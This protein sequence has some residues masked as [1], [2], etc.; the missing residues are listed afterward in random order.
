METQLKKQLIKE[1]EVLKKIEEF[2]FFEKE[3]QIRQT[4]KFF[5]VFILGIMIFH[6]SKIPGRDFLPL[7]V[8]LA[9]FSFRYSIFG[10]IFIISALYGLLKLES[11]QTFKP[12]LQVGLLIYTIH[13]FSSLFD[14]SGLFITNVFIEILTTGFPILIIVHFIKLRYNMTNVV[15]PAVLLLLFIIS[16]VLFCLLY[17]HGF[18]YIL[19]KPGLAKL[20]TMFRL[21]STGASIRNLHFIIGLLYT[22]GFLWLHVRRKHLI[23]NFV[24]MEKLVYLYK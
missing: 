2:K 11:T 17:I 1:T 15:F 10:N 21:A 5:T 19:L 6:L 12:Y 3:V 13:A 9:S 20:V 16:I 22:A 7:M 18:F 23:K 24:K 4:A 14:F 8:N